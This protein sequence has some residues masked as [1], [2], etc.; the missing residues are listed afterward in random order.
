MPI[1]TQGYRTNRASQ[2]SVVS[3]TSPT[4]LL[5]ANPERQGA[6]VYNDSG[7]IMYLLLGR[8]GVGT[9]G[10]APVSTTV[11]TTQ[12]TANSYYEVPF[13]WVGEIWGQWVTATGNARVTE[14]S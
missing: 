6:T 5:A 8:F 10:A 4:L 13:N 14:V 7:S 1:T 12:M 11:Y 3:A 2:T 9:T